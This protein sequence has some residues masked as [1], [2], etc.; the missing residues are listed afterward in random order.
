MID[1]QLLSKEVFSLH[2][3]V[4]VNLSQ[5]KEDLQIIEAEIFGKAS[6]KKE[7]SFKLIQKCISSIKITGFN[8]N[9]IHAIT[10]LTHFIN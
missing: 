1:Q 10:N 5:P 8:C 2:D 7:D 9:M 4:G 3:S 6:S